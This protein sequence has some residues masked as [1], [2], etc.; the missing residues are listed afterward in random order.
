MQEMYEVDGNGQKANV[1][2]VMGGMLGQI[3][4][5]FQGLIKKYRDEIPS[6]LDPKTV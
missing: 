1:V 5:C 4:I 2:G 6:L 3:I